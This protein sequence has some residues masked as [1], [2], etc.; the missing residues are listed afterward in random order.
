MTRLIAL[1]LLG[2]AASA[3]AFAQTTGK[4]SG[5]VVD[6]SGVPLIG[7][8]V[9]IDGTSRGA[10]TDLD[11]NYFIIGV[12]AGTHTLVASYVGFQTQRV[13]GVRVTVD[14]TTEVDFRLAEEAL[15]IDE[16]VVITATRTLV[17]SDRTS[18]SAKVDGET[19]LELPA[20]NF[21]DVVALQAGVTRG[22]DG[23]LH[24]RGGRASEIKYYVDGVAV[25]NPFTNGLSSPV[26]NSAVQEVEVIS[27]TFN[28]EY[29]QANSGIVNI[30]TRSGSDQFRGT[31][32]GS[33]GGYVSDRTSVYPDID[34]ASLTGERYVEGSL[35]GPTGIPNL[36]FFANGKHTDLGGHLFGREVFL[37]TDSSSF[38]GASGRDWF[39]QSNGDSAAVGMNSSEATTVLGKLTYDGIKNVRLALSATRFTSDSRPYN[40]TFR[41]V[42]G[43]RPT[44]RSDNTNVLFTLNHILTPRLFYDLR[45]TRYTTDFQQSVFEDPLDP[46]Y[47]AAYRPA[48]Q[49]PAFVFATGGLDAY[50]TQR[51]STTSAVRFDVT[52]QVGAYNLVKAGIEYRR[53]ELDFVEYLLDVNPVQYGDL[54]PRIPDQDTRRNNQYDRTPT[55]FS[56]YV[57]D[58]IE[59]KDLIVNV[60]VR[61]DR[62][63]AQGQVPNDF[64]DPQDVLGQADPYRETSVKSQFS[65][66]LGFAFP[67]TETGVVHASYGQFFQIPEFNRLYENPEFE[68]QGLNLTGYIGNADIDPQRT[69]QYEI[70][71]QQQVGRSFVVDLTAYYRDLRN[72]IG[73]AFYSTD[74]GSDTY[75]RYEN[76]DF[77]N[78]RGI[79]VSVGY[80]FPNLSGAVNYTYQSARGNGS[81]PRQ[82][83]FDRQSGLAAQ[84]VLIPLNWDQEHNLS[85]NLAT[86]IRGF[87]LSF[88]GT[89]LSGYPFTPIDERRNEIP[90]LRN[91][92]RFSPEVRLDVRVSRFVQLGPIRG[93]VFA[94]GENLADAYRPDRLP[95]LPQREIAARRAAGLD[96]INSQEAFLSNPALQPRPRQIR[97]GL[98]LDF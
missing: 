24:I 16:E 94:V 32:I 73:T 79:T 89:Y 90:E 13:E 46:G 74:V 28:A 25:S 36:Y 7:V 88:I 29:G 38:R 91:A 93:Q 50:W 70:G 2:L 42:P 21:Q 86:D 43:S 83:F 84:R 45:V 33:V 19:L 98:Q 39:I 35:S 31:F 59:Y 15:G 23:A 97:L 10:I 87:A 14:R 92:A 75:G 30:V 22:L 52:G 68:V 67:I 51:Q 60:G 49:E 78:V 41:L 81:D 65:P 71:L 76:V 82:A 80:R 53:N 72:L 6:Q 64:G 37:P 54:L 3:P 96:R 47:A 4:L 56:A 95:Q 55:E 44:Q 77:G 5:Q 20:D 18:S 11:G 57:Q 27:G 85:A 62:F 69:T 66:R 12:P 34:E 26:E 63:D 1:L 48:S 8:N 9:R 40:H 17:E 58:K 61:Y